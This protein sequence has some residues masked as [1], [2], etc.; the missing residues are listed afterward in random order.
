MEGSLVFPSNKIS[1]ALQQQTG[2][3]VNPH[4]ILESIRKNRD[5]VQISGKT[6][7]ISQIK[8]YFNVAS[9]RAYI[10]M[11]TTDIMPK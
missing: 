9:K 3:I 6:Y 7:D 1:Q 8:E 11:L 10:R 4:S 5:Y 2:I